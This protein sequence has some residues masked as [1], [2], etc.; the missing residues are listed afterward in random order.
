[1]FPVYPKPVILCYTECRAN[2]FLNKG[3]L[4]YGYFV[5]FNAG[6]INDFTCLLNIYADKLPIFP[7]VNHNA[8][9]LPL[10]KHLYGRMDL[11]IGNRFLCNNEISMITP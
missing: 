7:I 9:K 6:K 3:K 1:M 2:L 5:S 4:L 11:C 10:N 8:L